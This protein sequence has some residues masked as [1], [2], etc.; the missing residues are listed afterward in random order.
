M[1]AMHPQADVTGYLS[2]KTFVTI[3]VSWGYPKNAM[4]ASRVVIS[5]YGNACCKSTVSTNNFNVI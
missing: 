5:K 1:L 4:K 3:L 2:L